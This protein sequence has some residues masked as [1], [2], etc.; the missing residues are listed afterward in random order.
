[1][2]FEDLVEDQRTMT[3]SPGVALI[4]GVADDARNLAALLAATSTERRQTEGR[5]FRQPCKLQALN[6]LLDKRRLLE[7]RILAHR[8]QRE[9]WNICR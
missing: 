3:I 9:A 8:A 2:V 4:D 7:H 5:L 1:L 6:Q